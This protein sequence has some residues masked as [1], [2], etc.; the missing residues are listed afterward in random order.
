METV[1]VGQKGTIG[2]GPEG[3][4]QLAWNPGIVL[5]ADDVHVAM[6]MVNDIAG[7]SELPMLVDMGSAKSVTREAKSVFVIPCAASRI[8]LLGSSEVDRVI[9]NYT[10]G[11]QHRL[12][13]P[14]RFFTSR[15][16][17]ISWLLKS[18]C[19]DQCIPFF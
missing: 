11:R 17:A 12:P 5:E 3:I 13:C 19:P 2:L 7:D 18:P 8:A 6:A 16:E 1:A 4:I 14:T 9:A 15:S 10:I